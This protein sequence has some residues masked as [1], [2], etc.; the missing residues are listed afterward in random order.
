MNKKSLSIIIV[1]VLVIAGVGA[2][3]GYDITHPKSTNLPA[4]HVTALSP[5]NALATYETGV[6]V[7]DMKALGLPVSLAEQTATESGTWLSPSSTPQFVDLGWLPDW[8]DPIAQQMYPMTSYSNGGTFGAN[9]AWTT[10]ATLNSSIALSTAF[11]SN[12]TAQ[13][14][15]FTS[16]YHTFYKQYDYLWFPDPSTYFFVQPYINNFTYNAYENY[17]YN[18]MSYNMSYNQHGVRAVSNN[19]LTDVADGDSLAAPDFLDPSHGFYVQDGPLFTAVYQELYELNGTNIS[20]T[21]P[22]LANGPALTAHGGIKYQNY[23]ITLRS[24]IHFSTGTAVNATTVW[25]SLYR[26]IVMAQGVSVDNYGGMLFNNTAFSATSPYSIPIGWMHAMR[27]V[28]NTSAGKGIKFPDASN[29]SNMN[30][31]NTEYAAKYLANML[32]NFNPWSNSTQAAL[33][34]QPGQAVVVPDYSNGHGLNNTLNVTINLANPYPFFLSD[35][36]EWWGNIAD[37]VFLD[38]SGH[39]GVT[40]AAANNYTDSNGMPGTGP[41]NITGVGSSLD[42]VTLTKVANYWGNKYWNNNTEM[43]VGNFPLVAQPAHI[44]TI[45]IDYTIDHSG[46]VSGFTGNTY[47]ISVVSSSYIN[48][49]AGTKPYSELPFTSYF[50]DEGA[51][52]AVYYL[53]MNNHKFPTN[54]LDFREAMWYAINQT[55]IDKPYYYTTPSGHTTYLAQNYIGPASPNFAN[56]YDN[57]T[58]GLANETF[59]LALAEHYLN[60]AGQQGHFYVTLPNGTVL[61]DAAL[62]KSPSA[63]TVPLVLSIN[64]LAQN[65]LTATVRIF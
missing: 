19:T 18:M 24:G 62:K 13:S 8:P 57:A 60:L 5:L 50:K 45:I 55:A 52:P 61:G 30:K 32:S 20:Q 28:A 26:T 21:V 58:K 38:A 9:E 49:I 22:V 17:F 25:F 59:N 39:D 4:M 31:T 34:T 64:L 12:K 27:A 43:P 7:S 1:V 40:A 15:E 65:L 14:Q 46:R 53:S 11:S 47:Q 42:H 63:Y 41:Y 44:K 54:I 6:I 23:N 37:P 16:L 48:S 33:I 2:F 29:Y 10:N 51:S 35:M 36:A 56:L 3:F